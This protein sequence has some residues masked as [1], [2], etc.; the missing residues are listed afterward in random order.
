[1]ILRA[2]CARRAGCALRLARRAP[3]PHA[4]SFH[5]RDRQ[6]LKKAKGDGKELSEEDKQLHD[7]QKAEKAAL[8]AAADKLK[9]GK[10]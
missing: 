10:K 3:L 7:K 5:P 2:A 4:P 9:A 6:P 1:M 8:K